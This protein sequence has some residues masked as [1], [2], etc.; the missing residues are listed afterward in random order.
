MAQKRHD[1]P[2]IEIKKFTTSEIDAGIRKLR[3]RVEDLNAL[4][5]SKVKFDD[6]RVDN[7]KS[8][9]KETIREIF[10][11]NSPE[12]SEHQHHQI[13]KGGYNM[14]DDEYSRQTKFSA[15]IPQSKTIL[16]GLISRLEEKRADIESLTPSVVISS[17]VIS[18]STHKVFVVHGHDDEAKLNV[19][20]FLEK[21]ELEPIILNERPNEGRTVIE[22]FEHHSDVAYAVVLLTP[23]DIGKEKD[24]PG[25]THPRARQNVILELGYF[26]G[27]LGRARVC[28]LHKGSVEIPTDYHGVL[29]VPMDAGDGWKL[30]LAKEI[31][32]AGLLVD[33]NL[34]L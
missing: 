28:A 13:W 32:A 22:K 23:D 1:S 20:R 11:T 17:S 16:E 25:E 33:L 7:V 6:A 30:K 15:G 3:R 2:A 8:S 26:I 34:V 10:G 18:S 9:I 5:S 27:R 24:M 31:K 29:Y 19:A 12:F 21:L 4:E 14:M